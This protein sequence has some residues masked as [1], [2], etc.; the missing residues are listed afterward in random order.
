MIRFK[1]VKHQMSHA[2]LKFVRDYFV[3]AYNLLENHKQKSVLLNC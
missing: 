3:A 2:C 1:N